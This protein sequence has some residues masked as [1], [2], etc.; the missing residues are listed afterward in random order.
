MG[1]TITSNGPGTNNGTAGTS[2]EGDLPA[3]GLLYQLDLASSSLE[4]HDTPPPLLMAEIMAVV[5]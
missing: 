5:A 2:S 4:A 3:W 1:I